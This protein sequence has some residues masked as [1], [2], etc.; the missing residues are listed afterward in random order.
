MATIYSIGVTKNKS[1]D[2]AIKYYQANLPDDYIGYANLEL[3]NERNSPYEYD[4]II[5]GEF[6][7]Y[8][9]EVKNYRGLI[10]GNA[11]YWQFDNGQKTD[12]SP[13]ALTNDK[14]RATKSYLI[15]SNPILK[16]KV[17]VQTLI[18]LTNDQARLDIKDEQANLVMTLAQSVE[19][20][21]KPRG[22]SITQFIPTISN[23]F[24]KD[25]GRPAPRSNEIGDYRVLEGLGGD[26]FYATYMAEH[27]LVKMANRF[28]L[29][30]YNL[31]LP[32]KKSEQERRW[33]LILQDANALHHL[34]SHPN[35]AQAHLPFPW[36]DN[37]IVLPLSWIEGY[38]LR[39]L[40][41]EKKVFTFEFAITLIRQM[42]EALDYAHQKGV[43]HRNLRPEN[44]IIN[45]ADNRPILVNFD[46][47]R[48]ENSNLHGVTSQLK[49]RLKERYVAP[50]V[51]ESPQNL[52]RQS[53]MY[54]LG[55]I[56]F[57]LLTGQLPYKKIREVYKNDGLPHL[58]SHIKADLPHGQDL[59]ELI[60]TM[61][62]FDPQN[63]YKTLGEALETL[64]II[65]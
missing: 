62:A 22:S 15:Q 24:E 9:V 18:V 1:E 6:A 29:K 4:L 12:C 46:C 63:R 10:T 38:S 5:M 39:S 8:I 21:T 64:A 26:G 45:Q 33:N 50:E 60:N 49:G 14:A 34:G 11:S 7:V 55:I 27:R 65:G 59:D 31:N 3:L 57:E 30:V 16:D 2:K 37:K 36:E 56:A 47:A 51:H 48:I 61:C 35:I 32:N 19:F 54:S 23:I 40:L 25:F 28:L 58:P 20:M 52:T 13:I 44:I 43:I 17:W 42:G 41:D 53:D